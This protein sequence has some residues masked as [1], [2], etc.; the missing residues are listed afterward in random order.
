[1]RSLLRGVAMALLAAGMLA[2]AAAADASGGLTPPSLAGESM[3]SGA[4]SAVPAGTGTFETTL[5]CGPTSNWWTYSAS[6][7]AVGPYP[8]T[9]TESGTV[10]VAGP[11]TGVPAPLASLHADFTIA[12][13]D[14]IITG[15]KDLLFA[16]TNKGSCLALAAS[17]D[18]L[19]LAAASYR[20]QIDTTGGSFGDSGTATLDTEKSETFLLLPTGSVSLG[21]IDRFQETF[22]ASA[23]VAPISEPGDH[24]A[25][26]GW[27]TGP[28]GARISFGLE[29]HLTSSLGGG[30]NVID[31]ATGQHVKCLDVDSLMI[32]GTHA[33][34]MGD[35]TVD[36]TSTRYRIDVDDLGEPGTFD[37]FSIHTDSGYTAQ[38]RLQGGNIQIR[39]GS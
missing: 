6:G 34:L 19:F 31:H 2:A 7:I 35:A 23:G 26:G 3:L 20:A 33:T 24:V 30:C 13:G 15:T 1:M 11:A 22:D 8:G 10:Y 29:A 39:R 12:S 32:I 28:T 17:N 25:G 18:A 5:R 14:T 16:P 37:T 36:R 27:I 9:F 4:D 38:G 21:G